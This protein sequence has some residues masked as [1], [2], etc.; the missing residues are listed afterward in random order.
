MSHGTQVTIPPRRPAFAYGAVTLYGK[1]FQPS[2]T[3]SPFSYSA[4]ALQNPPDRTYNTIPAMTAVFYT[5][6]VWAPP[7]SL[8]TTWGISVDFFSSGY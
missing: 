6:M 8:A 1:A 7:R 3:S 2:S 4:K 5:D